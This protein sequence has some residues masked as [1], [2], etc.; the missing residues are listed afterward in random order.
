MIKYFREKLQGQH[1][2]IVFRDVGVV[3][4]KIV[5]AWN[6]GLQNGDWSG[7]ARFKYGAYD[8]IHRA[9]IEFIVELRFHNPY[10][11]FDCM[12]HLRKNGHQIVA[13]G[14]DKEDVRTMN[15]WI[16]QVNKLI[17][18]ADEKILD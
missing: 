15:G 1:L 2:N 4:Y 16:G 3:P 18:I 9:P 7:F 8:L 12:M 11:V 13:M 5:E 6:E 10:K 17:K 14:V